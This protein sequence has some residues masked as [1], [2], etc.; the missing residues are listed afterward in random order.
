MFVVLASSI[1]RT[2]L[3]VVFYRDSYLREEVR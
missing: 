1:Y 2:L 3:Y